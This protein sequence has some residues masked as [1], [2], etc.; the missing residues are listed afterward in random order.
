MVKTKNSN[1]RIMKNLSNKKWYK[2]QL[3]VNKQLFELGMIS[4]SEKLSQDIIAKS[5][6]ISQIKDSL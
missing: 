4:H 3:E 1:K 2:K 6:Y 5:I